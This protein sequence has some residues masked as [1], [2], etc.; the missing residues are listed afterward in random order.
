MKGKILILL[1]F[2][3]TLLSAQKPLIIEGKIID[4][5]SEA[6]PFATISSQ[7][8]Y[9]ATTTD[10]DG[11]YKLVLPENS[12]PDT[13]LI[14]HISYENK[15]L[16]LTKNTLNKLKTIK[17]FT[18]SNEVGIANIYA[19]TTRTY[20]EKAIENLNN[21][22]LTETYYLDG[23]YRQKHKENGKYVRLI[24]AMSLV[25]ETIFDRGNEKQ[26]EKFFISKI[27]R[28]NVYERNGDKHGDHFV[29]LMSEN[30]IN[31]TQVSFLNTNNIHNYD[32]SFLKSTN[33]LE[34]KIYFQNKTWQAAQNKSGFLTINKS[35]FAI[36]SIEITSTKNTNHIK[37][38]KSNW[39][40]QNGTYQAKF[41]KQNE[42]YHCSKSSKYY[43]HYVLNEQSNNIDFIVEEYFEWFTFKTLQTNPIDRKFSL[44]TNLYSKSYKYDA[45]F[46]NNTKLP[47]SAQKVFDD[48]NSFKDLDSQFIDD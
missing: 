25:E 28:S 8:T 3:A 40:F 4:S 13:L 5:N 15:A 27:R 37:T 21:N 48:L 7:K 30:P 46:W 10:I 19:Y 35:D 26:K 36:T 45:D 14:R 44:L 39:K 33:P 9:A 17:L 38:N 20:L 34:V 41:I 2:L 23:F 12:I 16:Y 1:C 43:N 47:N 6:I 42:K 32:F 31:Y 18:K 24:E 22:Y 11:K 29:D